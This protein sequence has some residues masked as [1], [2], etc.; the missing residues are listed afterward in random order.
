MLFVYIVGSHE[1]L[2]YFLRIL[3]ELDYIPFSLSQETEAAESYDEW[4]TTAVNKLKEA[5]P[6]SLKVTL[7]SVSFIS[8][9]HV[10]RIFLDCF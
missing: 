6:L 8:S 3:I 1:N 4:C 10:I 2:A 7:Q 5:S 9:L